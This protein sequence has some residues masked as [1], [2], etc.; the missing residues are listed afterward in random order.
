MFTL[1]FDTDN[2]QFDDL[3][4]GI[5]AVLRELATTIEN[6]G[7]LAVTDGGSVRDINGNTIGRWN[8]E[9]HR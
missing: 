4:S 3:T 2:T 9:S 7:A 8:L 1:K 5:V 6:S